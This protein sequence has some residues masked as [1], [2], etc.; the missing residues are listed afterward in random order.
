MRFAV[1]IKFLP[2][3]AAQCRLEKFTQLFCLQRRHLGYPNFGTWGLANSIRPLFRDTPSSPLLEPEHAQKLSPEMHVALV[4]GLE[5]FGQPVARG[6]PRALPPWR[7]AAAE[8]HKVCVFTLMRVLGERYRLA[9]SYAHTLRDR[10]SEG[11][12]PK[13]PRWPLRVCTHSAPS[14]GCYRCSATTL[15]TTPEITIRVRQ[16]ERPASL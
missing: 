1:F 5:V 8:W 9:D 2:A 12:R 7:L 10:A 16:H 4:G 6:P 14:Q 11:C 3:K 13:L 15:A